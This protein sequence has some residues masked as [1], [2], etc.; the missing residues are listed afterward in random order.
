MFIE[1]RALLNKLERNIKNQAVN[2]TIIN[3]SRYILELE[4]E[5]K[6]SVGDSPPSPLAAAVHRVSADDYRPTEPGHSP[7]VGHSYGPGAEGP[8]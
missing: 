6:S 5:A 2:D 8:N 4:A 1:G 3:S 7:G